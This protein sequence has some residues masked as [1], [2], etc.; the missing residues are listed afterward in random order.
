M[1]PKVLLLEQVLKC[2]LVSS[3]HHVEL[4][5]GTADNI[6][7]N[8]NKQNKYPSLTSVIGEILAF[9]ADFLSLSELELRLLRRISQRVCTIH[10]AVMYNQESASVSSAAC[11]DDIYDL[12]LPL[13]VHW[14]SYECFE[15]LK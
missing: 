7:I 11:H 2:G 14:S 8:I 10:W 5:P 6:N 4:V 13:F 9:I 15:I 1:R 3:S 12:F